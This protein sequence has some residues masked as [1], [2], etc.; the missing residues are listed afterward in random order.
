MHYKVDELLFEWISD[1]AHLAQA[2]AAWGDH[3]ALDTEFIRTDTYYPVPGLY[4]VASD[5]QIYLIDPLEIS[6]WQPMAD[7]L[8]DPESVIVMHACQED[9]ELM[10]HHLDLMPANVFDTQLANA[11]VS[12][13]YSL[14]YAA[15]VEKTT[16]VALDKHQ[17]RS[18]WLQRPL[19]DDQIKYAMDDVVYLG[20]VYQRLRD[21]LQQHDRMRWYQQDM[22][23]RGAYDPV[24]PDEYYRNVKKAWQLSRPQ[25]AVL[26]ALCAWREHTAREENVPRNRVVWDEHLLAFARMERL[27]IN[28]VYD[29]L[30]RGVAHRYAEKI[31]A[32]HAQGKNMALPA[33]LP[34]PLNASQNAQL[35]KLRATALDVVEDMQLAP[36]L[37]AR[38]RDIETCLRH[39]QQYQE[40]SE[41]YQAWRGELLADKF[42][43]RLAVDGEA[44]DLD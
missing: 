44:V 9:L 41:P 22:Q 23:E 2:V 34:K 3:I 14:S 6:D 35:K 37:L 13:E 32:Q 5:E 11:F 7:Y 16:G 43:Q 30:P 1:D 39:Y 8:T 19:S 24:A 33:A 21:A 4:Q 12:T 15:L 31:V 10:H 36:E 29:A 20:E 17:T 18:N 25:L 27:S 42:L 26:Q 38:K 28:H 40:L